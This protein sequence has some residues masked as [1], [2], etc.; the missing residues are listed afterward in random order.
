MRALKLGAAL[1]TL[2]ICL[3]PAAPAAR[4]NELLVMPFA[5][6]VIGGRPL[7]TPGPERGHLII[8]QREQ[9]KFTA[10]S[11]ANP[12]TCRHWTVHRFDIDCDGTRVPWVQ[13]VASAGEVGRRAWVV[14]GRL[15]LRMGSRWSLAPDDPCASESDVDGPYADRR[16]RRYCAERLAQAPPA[17]VEMPLGFAPIVGIDAIIVGKRTGPSFAG[18]PGPPDFATQPP[19]E[20][21]AEQPQPEAPPARPAGEALAKLPP[22]VKA[23]P[24]GPPQT[25]AEA[26]PK[27]EP[28]APSGPAPVPPKSAELPPLFAGDPPP[29][30]PVARPPAPEPNAAPNA[31]VPPPTP[32]AE[33]PKVAAPPGP[34]AVK[35]PPQPEPKPAPPATKVA[36]APPVPARE[37]PPQAPAKTTPQPEDKGAAPRIFS[38]SV[39]RTTTTGVVIAFAGLTLGLII[40]FTMARRREHAQ[41]TGL[42]RQRAKGVPRLGFDDGSE[43]QGGADTSLDRVPGAS[44]ANAALAAWGDHIPRT[45]K[46]ALKALGVAP[47]ANAAAIKKIVDALRRTWHPDR[48]RD[49]AD[50]VLREL[51]SKQVNAAWE[52]LQGERSEA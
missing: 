27:V 43:R 3:L 23:A 18:P 14:D 47:R 24:P 44:A 35:A 28:G 1:I 8:G 2:L 9:R 37:A 4:A 17:V 13:I 10:C 12:G 15:Q 20:A 51:R 25:V 49:E 31:A 22:P 5:C 38:F 26:H 16:M 33:G 30:V 7:L 52:L 42:Q 32:A 19:I 21:G 29:P 34:P 48:G 45:R 39:L 41:H 11:P 6:S 40:A 36:A 46:D 50:R